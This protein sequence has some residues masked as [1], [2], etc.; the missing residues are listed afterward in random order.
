MT[1]AATRRRPETRTVRLLGT[2]RRCPVCGE[3]WPLDNE[4]FV[5]RS[6]SYSTICRACLH[7]TGHVRRERNAEAARSYRRRT[8]I[9]LGPVP[10]Q[11]CAADVVWARVSG[12][13]SWR[14]PDLSPHR[15]RP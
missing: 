11:G 1:L 8:R 6:R 13:L 3:E 7:E 9:H 10:C 15:C 12:V 2:C 4:F 5:Q 14:E